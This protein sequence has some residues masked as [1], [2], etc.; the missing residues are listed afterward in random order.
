MS[1]LIII[2]PNGKKITKLLI[3]LDYDDTYTQDP[4][5]W[6]LFVKNAQLR[7]HEVVCATMRCPIGN[8]DMDPRLL[9]MVKVEFTC[10]QAKKI[11]LNSRSIYPH[12]W[13][14][15]RPDWIIF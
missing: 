15:D 6:L 12:I 14:D 11:V 5:F 9:A 2:M 13:I 4:E 10:G 1:N 3:A 8:E 7:G